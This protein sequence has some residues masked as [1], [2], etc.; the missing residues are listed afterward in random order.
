MESRTRWR[1]D[2]PGLRKRVQALVE[3]LR[4]G[5]GAQSVALFDDDRAALLPEPSASLCFWDAFCQA[6]CVGVG[7]N[8]TYAQLRSTGHFEHPCTCGAHT[9]SG[10]VIHGRWVLLLIAPRV[11][12]S[13]A[14]LALSSGLKGLA[15][16]LPPCRPADPV[17]DQHREPPSSGL[18]DRPL[19]WVRPQ[20]H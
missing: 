15:Q 1:K 11:L 17:A 3:A 18:V 7:W 13:G 14:A 2:E 12:D 5:V 4:Q 19:W 20:R 8:E 9:I 10:F 16:H 6:P